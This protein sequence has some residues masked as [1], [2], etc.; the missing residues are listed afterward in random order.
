MLSCNVLHTF[1]PVIYLF[2]ESVPVVEVSWDYPLCSVG[3]LGVNKW[4][5]KTPSMDVLYT[6]ISVQLRFCATD[7]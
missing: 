6:H 2:A 3:R 4:T 1:F 5:P 7:S